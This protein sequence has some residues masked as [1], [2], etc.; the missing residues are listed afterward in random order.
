[1]RVAFQTGAEIEDRISRE[2]NINNPLQTINPLLQGLYRRGINQVFHYQTSTI[3]RNGTLTGNGHWLHLL[4]MG[5]Y[6]KFQFA[7]SQG[8]E[9]LDDFDAIFVRGDDVNGGTSHQ[10]LLID[11]L[12]EIALMNSGAATVLTRDKFEIPRRFSQY[13]DSIPQTYTI[14]SVEDLANAW[15]N[16]RGEAVVLKGRYGSGGKEVEKFPRTKLGYQRGKTYF[17]RFGQLVAQE[18]LPE[19]SEGDVRVVALDGEIIGALRRRSGEGWKTNTTSGGSRE[20]IHLTPTMIDNARIGLELFPDVRFQG[21]D[22]TYASGR[23]IETNAFPC[24][25]GSL[26]TLY[27][28]GHEDK[29]INKLME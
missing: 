5:Q 22:M 28:N 25:L 7:Y 13:P 27:G 3:K 11:G 2:Q 12:E 20:P 21:L 23:F 8:V 17:Q 29:I 6:G 4:N 9:K 18:Y 19:I 24:S 16:I 15:E 1:M 26:N 10:A 14:E